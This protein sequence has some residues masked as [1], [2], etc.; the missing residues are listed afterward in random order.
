VAGPIGVIRV[1]VTG[2]IA[3]AWVVGEAVR[4]RKEPEAAEIPEMGHVVEVPVESGAEPVVE[5]GADPVVNAGAEPVVNAGAECVVEA[6]AERGVNAGV[7]TT[8][9]EATAVEATAR[10]RLGRPGAQ[11]AHHSHQKQRS[12]EVDH[13]VEHGCSSSLIAAS[14]GRRSIKE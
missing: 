7:E 13:V 11:H 2:G 5:T 12:A 3:V 9:V 6:G 4:E 1:A 14:V 10:G 8:A